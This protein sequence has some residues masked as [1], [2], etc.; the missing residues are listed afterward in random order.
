MKRLKADIHTHS[1]DDPRDVIDYSAEML[2][3]A[4]AKLNMDVLAIT[5]HQTLLVS[6][7]LA[8][9]ASRRGILLIPGV[10]LLV[11]GKHVVILNPD[12]EQASATTFAELRA[13]GRR[14]AAVV[15]PHPYYP[16]RTAL[17]SALAKN[18][19]VFDA[20]EY[21]S[22]Y[23]RGLNPNRRAQAVARRHGLP[24]VGSSDSHAMPYSDSTC[25]WIDAEPTVAGVIRAIR[26]GRVEV[27]TRSRPWS[28]IARA[29]SFG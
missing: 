16:L 8:L 3:E 5:L 11:E 1:A 13:L 27:E 25:T 2:I 26:T 15:A 23:Y 6:E 20:V 12:E 4:G 21:C 22:V 29:A 24:M 19:D 9:Y 28:E 14:E 18:I 17:R 10:E 7:R